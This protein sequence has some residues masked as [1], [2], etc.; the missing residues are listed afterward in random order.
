MWYLLQWECNGITSQRHVVFAAVG[1]IIVTEL[2]HRDMWYLLQWSDGITPQ[3]HA[4]FAAVGV[5]ELL[6]RDMW[7]LLQWE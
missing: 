4:V 5:M 1:V 6:H 2:L 7:Y 3:R